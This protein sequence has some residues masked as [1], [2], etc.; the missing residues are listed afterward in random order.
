M[1]NLVLSGFQTKEQAEEFLAWYGNSGEQDF[2]IHLEE[3]EGD[4]S[5]MPVD[6]HTT[7]TWFGGNYV[8]HLEVFKKEQ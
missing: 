7:P 6:Y 8:A 1:Y 2:G 3:Q 5:F 4:V